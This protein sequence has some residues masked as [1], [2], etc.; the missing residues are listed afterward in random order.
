VAV[1]RRCPGVDGC[2]GWSSRRTRCAAGATGSCASA[3]LAHRLP[4]CDAQG[5]L[6]YGAPRRARGHSRTLVRRGRFP[7]SAPPLLSGGRAARSVP[8]GHHQFNYTEAHESTTLETTSRT[9]ETR[10]VYSR[11]NAQTTHQTVMYTA[12]PRHETHPPNTR[13]PTPHAT[14]H[15]QDTRHATHTTPTP[16]P[17]KPFPRKHV[18]DDVSRPS[19]AGAPSRTALVALGPREAARRRPGGPTERPPARPAAPPLAVQRRAPNAAPPV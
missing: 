12:P 3:F 4:G 19:L 1:R 15:D 9:Q 10:L 7:G 6:L 8:T 11:A 5:G 2:C 17:Q 13:H 18:L 16:T 14:K